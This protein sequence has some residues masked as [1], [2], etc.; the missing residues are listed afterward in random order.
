[1]PEIELV[2]TN[3]SPTMTGGT[4]MSC[5]AAGGDKSCV[6]SNVQL[7]SDAG[8]VQLPT[9]NLRWNISMPAKP[10]IISK[11]VVAP[12]GTLPSCGCE[13]TV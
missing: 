2:I 8:Q 9:A 5:Y 3:W 10:M 4:P 13:P 12:S 11:A 1:V 7:V 6:N